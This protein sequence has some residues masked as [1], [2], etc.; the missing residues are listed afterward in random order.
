[1]DENLSGV[2]TNQIENLTLTGI[3]PTWV[4][5]LYFWKLSA[6]LFDRTPQLDIKDLLSIS[7]NT[8]F[9]LSELISH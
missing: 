8:D 3:F 6:A 7:F 1:M 5:F 2:T 4:R 9:D